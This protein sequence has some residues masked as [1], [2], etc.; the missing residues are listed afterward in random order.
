[1]GQ[2]AGSYFTSQ[3]RQQSNLESQRIRDTSLDKIAV[4]ISDSR[5]P[6]THEFETPIFDDKSSVDEEKEKREILKDSRL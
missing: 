2:L 4:G 1:M 3:G 6:L 5:H